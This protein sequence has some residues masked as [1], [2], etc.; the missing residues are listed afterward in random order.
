LSSGFLQVHHHGY[1][2]NKSVDST[3]EDNPKLSSVL[4]KEKQIT[5]W[6]PRLESFALASSGERTKGILVTGINPKTED[7]VSNLKSKLVAGSFLADSDK[8]YFAGRRISTIPES[9]IK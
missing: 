5:A 1:W 4:D 6:T 3:F 8:R 9:E 2:E 7:A